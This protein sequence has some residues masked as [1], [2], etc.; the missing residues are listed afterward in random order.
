[1]HCQ[2]RVPGREWREALLHFRQLPR[3]RGPGLQE[4]RIIRKLPGVSEFKGGKRCLPCRRMS[5]EGV[6]LELSHR[7]MHDVGARDG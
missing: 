7:D 4:K 6:G 3:Q 5:L 2:R 1:M